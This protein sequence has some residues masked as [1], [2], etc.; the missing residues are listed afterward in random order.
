MSGERVNAPG[1]AKF[2]LSDQFIEHLLCVRVVRGEPFRS[3][4]AVRITIPPV[5][6]FR[7]LAF[8]PRSGRV[9]RRAV[10]VSVDVASERLSEE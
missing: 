1:F 7:S 8:L 2:R 6:L 3:L 5:L 9:L 4:D 10:A